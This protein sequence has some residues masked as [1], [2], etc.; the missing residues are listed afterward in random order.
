MTTKRTVRVF[1]KA[2]DEEE[3]VVEQIVS[4]FENVDLGRDR[5]KTGAFENSLARWAASGDPIPVIWSHEWDDPFAHIGEVIEAKE[6]PAG[7]PLLPPEIADLGGLWTKYKV[8][9]EP[10]ADQ[11][12]K[13]LKRRRVREASFAYDIVREKRQNDGTTDLLELD[14]IEVGPTLKGMN[15]MTQLLAAKARADIVDALVKSGLDQSAAEATVAAALPAG[16]AKTSHTFIPSDDEP[17]RCS[18]CSLTRNTM[19]HLNLLST[20]PGGAKAI[21]D[22]PGSIEETLDNHYRAAWDYA[23][24]HGLGLGGFYALHG[25][26]TYPAEHRGVYLVEGWDDPW[27]EGAYFEFHF[28]DDPELGLT[29]S[30]AVEVTIEGVVTPKSRQRKDAQ[31]AAERKARGDRAE[32]SATPAAAPAPSAPG[33]DVAALLVEVLAVDLADGPID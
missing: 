26:A 33:A 25:E 5:V 28:A 27:G 12:F 22:L 9:E 18:I 7:D 19:G 20:E 14:I 32:K 16:G 6:L 4:V 1:T 2:V 17:E 13:L 3:R 21:V 10:F 8:D 24:E 23:A 30:E 15:P 31:Q 29:V 11:V